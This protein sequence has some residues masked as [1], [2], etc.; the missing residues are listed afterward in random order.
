MNDSFFVRRLQRVGHLR[1]NPQRFINRD[2]TSLDALGQRL[3]R[4]EFHHQKAISRR[5]LESVD[6]RNV[7]MI[8]RRQHAR[9]ALESRHSVRLVAE[10]FGK[11]LDGHTSPQ[12]RVGGLIDV[13]HSPAAQVRRNLVVC[14]LGS[15]HSS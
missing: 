6:G 7:G 2:R 10:G 14:E 15:N 3:S 4:H 9:F 12:L 5:L 13:T 1:G 8:Q 11:E